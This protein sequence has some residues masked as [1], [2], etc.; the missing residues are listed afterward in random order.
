MFPS[1]LVYGCLVASPV[2]ITGG[3]VAALSLIAGFRKGFGAFTTL[4]P[5]A[6]TA[7]LGFLALHG[8]FFAAG[9]LYA[10]GRRGL[11]LWLTAPVSVIATLVLLATAVKLSDSTQDAG[12]WL[13]PTMLGAGVVA[14]WGPVVALAGGK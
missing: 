5:A 1:W 13:V 2:V 14:Y 7:A 12:R 11:A 3:T 8:G 10:H 4:P 9:F 6:F